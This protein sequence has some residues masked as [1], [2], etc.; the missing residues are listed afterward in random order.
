MLGRLAM[1]IA[2]SLLCLAAGLLL[3]SCVAHGQNQPREFLQTMPAEFSG[4]P[5]WK[6]FR[7]HSSHSERFF[8]NLTFGRVFVHEHSS[9]P[10]I[11]GAEF[12]RDDGRVFRCFRKNSNGKYALSWASPLR[13]WRR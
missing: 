10:G 9:A 12:V 11:A 1:N 3:A 13:R 2:R 5:Y 7:S 8:R 4:L 6:V